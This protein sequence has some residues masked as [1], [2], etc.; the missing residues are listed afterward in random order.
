MVEKKNCGALFFFLCV[1]VPC[2]D[3]EATR[4]RDRDGEWG[5]ENQTKSGS[6]R[7]L[8]LFFLLLGRKEGRALSFALSLSLFPSPTSLFFF[9][10]R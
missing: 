6:R 4:T 3:V 1:V 5:E 7:L 9:S 10:K 2:D 8:F